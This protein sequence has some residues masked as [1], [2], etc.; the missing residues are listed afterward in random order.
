MQVI[1]LHKFFE[2]LLNWCQS[3]HFIYRKFP[4]FWF[5]WPKCWSFERS[6]QSHYR[7]SWG[8]IYEWL[9]VKKFGG[10]EQQQLWF[11]GKKK[12]QKIPKRKR[13]SWNSINSVQKKG[14]WWIFGQSS[15]ILSMFDLWRKEAYGLFTSSVEKS[16]Q[17]LEKIHSIFSK[18]FLVIYPVSF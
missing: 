18:I 13:T 9:D 14:F 15:K 5:N 1:I 4:R 16:L 12:S 7:D 3:I 2:K 6:F 11:Q 10:C 8:R 17:V